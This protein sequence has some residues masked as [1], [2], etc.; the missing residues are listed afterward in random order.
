MSK[1]KRFESLFEPPPLSSSVSNQSF[2]TRFDLR[3]SLI[4]TKSC[5]LEDTWLYSLVVWMGKY[6]S[7]QLQEMMKLDLKNAQSCQGNSGH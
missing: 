5:L 4:E 1:V 7:G 2:P 6:Q 3:A